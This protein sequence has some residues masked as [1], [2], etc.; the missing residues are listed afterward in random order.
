MPRLPGESENLQGPRAVKRMV[1]G[2]RDIGGPAMYRAGRDIVRGTNELHAAFEAE[3]LRIDRTRNEDA[4]N[5]LSDF[6]VNQAIGEGG[7]QTMKGADAVTKPLLKDTLKQFDA[8]VKTQMDGLDNERQREMFKA[9]SDAIRARVTSGVLSHQ[10]AEDKVYQG[11]VMK[12][13]IDSASNTVSVHPGELQSELVR[14]RAGNKAYAETLG[15][16]GNDKKTK[17]VR[18]EMLTAATTPV[19]AAAIERAINDGRVVAAK[20]LLKNA[21]KAGEIDAKVADRLEDSLR[22]ADVRAAGQAEFDKIRAKYGNDPA[23]ALKA[24]MAIKNPEARDNATARVR[25]WNSDQLRLEAQV[26]KENADSAWKTAVA[27]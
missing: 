20:T 11:Q 21:R 1:Q 9:H 22:V 10:L 8:R 26:D 16:G 15:F 24:A 14:V 12:S 7:Y 27:T 6:T 4:H 2:P 23:G 25:A 17:M 18:A 3:Q 13:T 19:H 5:Q